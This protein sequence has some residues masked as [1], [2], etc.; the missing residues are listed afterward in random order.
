MHEGELLVG[1]GMASAI[2]TVKLSPAS[3]RVQLHDDGRATVLTASHDIGTGTYTSLAQLAST[4]LQIDPGHVDVKLADTDL[5]SAPASAGSQTSGSVGSAVIAAA[6]ETIRLLIQLAVIGRSSP[7]FGWDS[8]K[9]ELS[10][11]WLRA[12][13]ARAPQILPKELLQQL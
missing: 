12:A 5:P 10:G 11:G 13:E 2:F 8:S 3:A 7:F 9:V 6:R 4:E 1:W